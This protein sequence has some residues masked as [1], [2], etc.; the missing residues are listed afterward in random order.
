MYLLRGNRNTETAAGE[1]ILN[2]MSRF[3]FFL[4]DKV[5]AL[6]Q[7]LVNEYEVRR[8]MLLK[9]LDVTILSFGWSDRAKVAPENILYYTRTH[10]VHVLL[11]H[12]L[13]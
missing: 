5:E 4:Q 11:L 8:K 10:T 2:Q 6:N 9:R 3:F 7:S 13:L 12:L 1:C